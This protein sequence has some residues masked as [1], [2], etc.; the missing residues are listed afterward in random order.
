MQSFYALYIILMSALIGYY[1]MRL[2]RVNGLNYAVTHPV[3]ILAAFFYLYCIIPALF[4]ATNTTVGA[5]VR[6]YVHSDEEIRAHLIRTVIFLVFLILTA[7][8]FDKRP[9]PTRNKL[10]F[11][12]SRFTVLFAFAIFLIANL[13]MLGLSAPIENYYDF[14]SRF[15]H[16]TGPLSVLASVAKRLVWGIT[17]ILI[18]LLSVRYTESMKMYVAAVGLIVVFLVVNT[19]GARADAML[20]IIQAACFR[21]LWV[22]KEISWSKVAVLIPI[23]ALCLYAL[24]YA[25]FARV[26]AGSSFELL[27]DDLLL[28][29][30]GEFFALFFPS[31]E[32]HSLSPELRTFGISV[33]FK[34]VLALIPFLEI[35]DLDLMFWYWK[36]FAPTA[37]VAPYTMG[38]L[39]DPAIL[40]EWWLVVEAVVIGR[41]AVA[42]NRLRWAS[43]PY[44]LAAYGYL[45]SIGVLVLKYNMLTYVDLLLNNF[46][47]GALIMWVII[48]A[49]QGQGFHIETR[50]QKLI[51]IGK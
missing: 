34:D 10:R 6:W 47:P 23:A 49:Q 46:L 19:H 41:L 26:D 44:R 38:V 43:D 22:R 9:V 35:G 15:D 5:P 3:V 7:I 37:P 11:S 51:Y 2:A 32:L 13:I 42:A 14:Y 30:P 1:F 39:A 36:M 12:V 24:R 27:G 17:P 20:A 50:H 25:E 8:V 45:A 21:M 18:F 16:L 28:L 29:A 31:I 33:Y 4:F 48:R 40:G